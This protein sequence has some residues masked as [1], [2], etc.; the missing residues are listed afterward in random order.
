MNKS[1]AFFEISSVMNYYLFS[2]VRGGGEEVVDGRH[3]LRRASAKELAEAVLA[4][5][6]SF[7]FVFQHRCRPMGFVDSA[8]SSPNMELKFNI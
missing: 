5:L 2:G 8:N 4:V 6:L 1:C 3:D 7:L